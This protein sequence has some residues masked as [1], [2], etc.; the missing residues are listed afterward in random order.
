MEEY[1]RKAVILSLL[2]LILGAPEAAADWR[3]E[4]LLSWV[5][6]ANS[7]AYPLLLFMAVAMAERDGVASLLPRGGAAGEA[8]P[9]G[10]TGG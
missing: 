7:A 3:R 10:G 9:L 5:A 1:F 4:T 8:S 6:T 2:R